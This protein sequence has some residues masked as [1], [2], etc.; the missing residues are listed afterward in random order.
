MGEIKQ[1]NTVAGLTDFSVINSEFTRAR[2]RILYSGRNRNRTDITESALNK[3]IERKGYANVPVVAHLYKGDDGKWRVGGHDSKF[4]IDSD[5][6]LEIID[7]TVPFGVIPESCNP[8]FEDVTE[9]SGEIK[10]YFCVDIIL[11]THRYNIME[12]VKSDEIWFNQS[13]EISIDYC[14]YDRDDYCV[15]EDFS[16]S[17]LCLLNHDPYNKENEVEPCFPSANVTKFN[18]DNFK[19][20]FNILYNKLKNFEDKGEENL[21]ITQLKV[22]LDS[23]YC[24]LSATPDAVIA[25][26]KDNYELFEIPYSVNIENSDIVF[27]YEKAAKK[28]AAVS[29]KEQGVSF[30]TFGEYVEEVKTAVSAGAEKSFAEKFETEKRE[31]TNGLAEKLGEL[32]AKYEA[33]KADLDKANKLVDEYKAAEKKAAD[34]RHKAEID[35]IINSY[36][37][38]LER[39]SDFYIYRANVDY[40]KTPEQVETDMLIIAGKQATKGNSAGGNMTFANWGSN[41]EVSAESKTAK[42]RYGDIFDKFIN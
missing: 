42:G 10:R 17:A 29:D 9:K 34:D 30:V 41:A 8:S 23:K 28:Y 7:E 14:H 35:K 20:E 13:M 27:D 31:I 5:G 21:E 37:A 39:N 36:A 3:L 25:M 32:T 33:C 38:Q 11:W 19:Q 4:V 18:L 15:I 2:C 6:N 12:A 24:L 26:T 1:F 22:K 16:L 40:S